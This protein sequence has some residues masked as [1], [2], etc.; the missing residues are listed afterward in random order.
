MCE[1][2]ER[3]A[4]DGTDFVVAEVELRVSDFVFDVP[5]LNVVDEVPPGK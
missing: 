1:E 5:S 3:A 2:R 4:V